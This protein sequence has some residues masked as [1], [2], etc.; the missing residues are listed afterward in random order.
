MAR[1]QVVVDQVAG[2][3]ELDHVAGVQVMVDHVAGV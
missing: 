1:A 2:A 3:Q